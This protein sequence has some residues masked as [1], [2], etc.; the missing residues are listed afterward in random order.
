MK[1]QKVIALLMSVVL[2]IGILGACTKSDDSGNDTVSPT[3]SAS[4]DT[5]QESTAEQSKIT[6][7]VVYWSMWNENEPQ[8]K[9]YKHGLDILKQTAPGINV[10]VNWM[11]RDIKST[12]LP[13]IKAGEKVDIFEFLAYADSPDAFFDMSALFEKEAY[14]Q[15]GVTVRDSLIKGDL[16]ANK[17]AFEAAGLKGGEYGLPLNPYVMSMFYNKALFKKAGIEKAPTTWAEFTTVCDKLVAAGISPITWDDA[18]N[19]TFTSAWLCRLIGLGN[20]KK[21]AAS[22]TDQEWKSGAIEKLFN[23]LQE[24]ADKKY[25]SPQIATNKYPA[26]QQEFALGN[27]AMYFNASYFPGEVKE[28]A[29]PD[30]EWGNFAFPTIDG[31]VEKGTEVTM[32]VNP[33]YINKNTKVS[34]AAMEVLRILASKEVQSILPEDGVAPGTANTDWPAAIADQKIIAE[35]AT[36]INPWANGFYSDFINAVVQPEIN[37]LVAGQVKADEAIKTVLTQTESFKAAK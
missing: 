25:F 35:T 4:T 21:L 17:E 28:T 36:Q 15:P 9:A 13:A 29:G 5:A 7:D 22:Q 18:Y 8:A 12:L 2:S 27:A 31:G 3:S 14:G 33:I 23:T 16:L 10:K 19:N 26:G 32:G 34:E 20:M 11:G 1:K 6:G 37:K 24:M 30:F